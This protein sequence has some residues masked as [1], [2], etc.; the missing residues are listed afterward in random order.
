MVW[1]TIKEGNLE[2]LKSMKSRFHS[3]EATFQNLLVNSYGWNTLHAASYFGKK[4][5]V[6]Y[7]IEEE[8]LDPMSVNFNGWNSMIFAVMGGVGDDVVSYLLNQSDLDH[9]DIY[10]KTALEY[11]N[12]INPNGKVTTLL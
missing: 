1:R 3:S 2:K 9:T 8:R 7:L 4:H 10:G 6:Q 12:S 5:I 11:A